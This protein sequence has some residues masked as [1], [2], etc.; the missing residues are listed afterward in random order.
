[1][2]MD[3]KFTLGDIAGLLAMVAVLIGWGIS[4]ERRL[5]IKLSADRFHQ[6]LKDFKDNQNS[7]QKDLKTELDTDIR[8]LRERL[9][10]LPPP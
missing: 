3:S 10:Q 6:E 9:N 5:A 1:M 4:V 8:I 7:N 2:K